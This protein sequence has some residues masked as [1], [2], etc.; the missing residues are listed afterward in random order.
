MTFRLLQI[1]DLHLCIEPKRQNALA[2]RKRRPADIIDTAR[3]QTSSFGVLSLFRPVSYAPEVLDGIAQFCLKRSALVD[4][5]VITGDLATTGKGTDLKTAQT[6]VTAPVLSAFL[7]SSGLP[8]LQASGRSIYVVPGNHDR[9]RDDAGTPG[10]SDF[11]L[12]FSKSYMPNRSDRISYITIA[13]NGEKLSL[14]FADFCLESRFHCA[15]PA[16]DPFGQGFAYQ[17]IIDGLTTATT[18][19]RALD[20]RRCVAWVVHF[21]P[22]DCGYSLELS[23]FGSL[24]NAALTYDIPLMLCGHTHKSSKFQ[25]GGLTV[26]CAGSACCVD[27]YGAHW[28]HEIE[29]TR[30]DQWQIA[31]KNYQWNE[32]RTEFVFSHAD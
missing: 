5:I 17:R 10:G 27:S 16:V 20:S 4:R 24:Q 14:I 26:Y 7:S 8:T 31:R 30:V 2:L 29:I 19:L 18:R 13:K 28:M 32:A 15:E 6:F 3:G 11:F 22:F 1:S 9:Y 21:A 12:A 25:T 23:G